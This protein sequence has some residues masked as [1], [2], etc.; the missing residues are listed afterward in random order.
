MAIPARP[1]AHTTGPKGQNIRVSP[2]VLDAAA[3]DG[4]ELLRSL[5]TTLTG[6]TQTEAESRARATGPNEVAQ[7]Q[8]QGWPLRLLKII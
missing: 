2:A 3:K 1:D 7:E 6:L 8:R 4:E 5:K